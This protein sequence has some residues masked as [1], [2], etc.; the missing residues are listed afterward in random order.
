MGIFSRT[1]EQKKEDRSKGGKN[2]GNLMAAGTS[3][4]VIES[5]TSLTAK[6][7]KD[8]LSN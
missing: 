8:L 6:Y 2:G 4:E 5:K 7:L 3:E 1:E